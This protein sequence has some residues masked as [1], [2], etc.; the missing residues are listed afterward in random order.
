MKA[1]IENKIRFTNLNQ[2][3]SSHNETQNLLI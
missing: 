3:I 2:K 1:L